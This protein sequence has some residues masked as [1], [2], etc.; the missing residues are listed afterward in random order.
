M[1]RQA[2][3][4]GTPVGTPDPGA[5]SGST[6]GSLLGGKFLTLEDTPRRGGMGEVYICRVLGEGDEVLPVALKSFQ[7][8]FFF[9][10]EHREAFIR[11]ISVWMRLNGLPYVVPALSIELLDGHPFV[12]MPVATTGISPDGTLRG[13][14]SR[15][16]LAPEQAFGLAFQ[17]SLAMRNAAHVLGDFVHGD[18]KPENA[19]FFG[20]GLHVSDFGLARVLADDEPSALESTHAYRAPEAWLGHPVT[21]AVDVYAFGVMLFEMLHGTRPFEEKDA[22]GWCDAHLS[23]PVPEPTTQGHALA[24]ALHE[25]ARACLEK[26][27]VKRPATFDAVHDMLNAIGEEHDFLL[28]LRVMA[29]AAERSHHF[30][31]VQRQ[32]RGASVRSLLEIEQPA[33][34]LELIEQLPL[35][36]LDARMWCNKA[37]ALSLLGRDEEALPCLKTALEMGPDK[38]LRHSCLMELA[39]SLKR[40]GLFGESLRILKNLMPY[41]DEES[42]PEL[43]TNIASVHLVKEE[44]EEAISLLETSLRRWPDVGQMWA[45]LGLAYQQQER[46]PEAAEAFQRTLRLT[47]HLASIRFRL[48]SLLMDELKRPTDA[49]IALRDSYQQGFDHPALAPRML[50]CELMLDRYEEALESVRTLEERFGKE[51]LA[52]VRRATESRTPEGARR[53]MEALN[54]LSD[55]FASKREDSLGEPSPNEVTPEPEDSWAE[56]D[57]GLSGPFMNTRMYADNT[58]GFDFYGRPEEPQYLQQLEYAYRSIQ[59]T[60]STRMGRDLRTTVLY[61]TRCPG[62]GYLV[63]TNRDIGYELDCRNCEQRSITS[64]VREPALSRLLEEIQQRLGLET[65]DAEDIPLL[66]LLQPSDAA[67]AGQ[68]LAVCEAAGFTQAPM[69]RPDVMFVDRE[70]RARRMVTPDAFRV[71]VEKTVNVSGEYRNGTPREVR[72]LLNRLGEMDPGLRSLSTERPDIGDSPEARLMSGD[73]QGALRDCEQR[74]LLNPNDVNALLLKTHL[75]IQQNKAQEALAF[76]E[77]AKR[78]GGSNANVEGALGMIRAALGELEKAATHFELALQHDPLNG[79]AMFGLMNIYNALGKPQLA[80]EYAAR[81]QSRGGLDL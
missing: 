7:P 23:A 10:R 13:L 41:T 28:C 67:F 21:P 60:N 22:R 17:L 20:D 66:V 38:E 27:P 15:T 8:R 31:D 45:N 73:L 53:A 4:Q 47:P 35:E 16:R 2:T 75:L 32:L 48:A 78:V 24:A 57:P 14:L 29:S 3:L 25:L 36:E 72:L 81:L 34:A 80:A 65:Y 70:A 11:E 63:L 52:L 54:E 62:C 71:A 5:R 6:R 50:W 37:T 39:L 40:L 30:K 44:P 56:P 12:V 19:L 55:R 58:L 9:S 42:L 46:F 68:L 61:F 74:L 18:L 79:I 43:I 33:L 49:L 77:R 69:D 76:A 59:N 64:P 26:D 1:T 51:A